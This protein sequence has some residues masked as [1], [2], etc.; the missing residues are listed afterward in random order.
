MKTE[1]QIKDK[2]KEHEQKIEELLIKA[3]PSGEAVPALDDFKVSIL[4]N[5]LTGR[6]ALLW[7]LL[8]ADYL[9][10]QDTFEKRVMWEI[11]CY[12]ST[13]IF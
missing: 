6:K 10:R 13:K 2:I 5:Y 7:V 12:E 8:D 1:Q 3:K 4:K 9:I 11:I